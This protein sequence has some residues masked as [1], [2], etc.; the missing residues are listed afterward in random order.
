LD[1]TAVNLTQNQDSFF[2]EFLE[3]KMLF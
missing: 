3:D 1:T 2:P